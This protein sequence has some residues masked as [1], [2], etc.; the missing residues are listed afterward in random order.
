VIFREAPVH[1]HRVA[2]IAL[3][4]AFG[5]AAGV[6]ARA[7][8]EPVLPDLK[9]DGK[10]QPSIT[11]GAGE[12]ARDYYRIDRDA[13]PLTL[14]G[15]GTLRIFVRADIPPGFDAPDSAWVTLEGLLGFPTQRWALGLTSSKGSVYPSG[16]RGRPSGAERIALIVPTGSNQLR[17]SGTSDIGENVYA[18]FT[19]ER[20]ALPPPVPQVIPPAETSAPS[21]TPPA[22]TRPPKTPRKPAP[23]PPTWEFG[24]NAGLGAIY[25]DNILRLSAVSIEEFR[26][27]E[28]TMATALN[29]YDDLIL[30]GTLDL[31][32]SR[33]LL[34]HKATSLRFFYE[35]WQYAR[36]DIKTNEDFEIRVR[37][38]ARSADYLELSFLYAPAGY[39][40]ELSDRPP[41]VPT[42]VPRVYLPFK[43]TRS[44]FTATYRW[45]PISWLSVRGIGGRE[46]RYY[47]R[48]FLENDLW[49]WN[50]RVGLDAV[51]GRLTTTVH[52]GYADVAAR[53]YDS[54]GETLETA[55]E[56]SDG[57]YE[58]DWY[59]LQFAYRPKKTPYAPAAPHGVVGWIQRGAAQVDRGLIRASTASLT[60]M[61]DY[62]RQF[63]TSQLP[64]SVDA[65]HVGRLDQTKQ[66]QL[67]WASRPV[68]RSVTLEAGWRYTRR[69]ANGAGSLIGEDPSEEKDYTG[70]RY[71]LGIATPLR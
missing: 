70:S 35:R 67:T 36:N 64:L 28:S 24:A 52:Y 2:W 31:E 62:Q 38:A 49:E 1:L 5:L 46:L 58:K 43:V 59:R 42:S 65:L 18:A 39:I 16:R 4:G 11:I 53:G 32:V 22:T 23:K 63:Y 21:E 25:D 57:S 15:P 12:S 61:L 33:D 26:R 3:L 55:D 8:F 47:N 44:Q 60:L 10:P 6:P 13:C 68:W 56:G 54:V 7:E 66:I 29:T 51:W 17:V 69:S 37:Q 20:V 27:N 50:G 40:K 34:F 45:R 48:P 71:W 30:D 41:F 14:E 9:L 19:Y